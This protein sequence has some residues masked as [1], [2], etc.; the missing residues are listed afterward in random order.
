VKTPREELEHEVKIRARDGKLIDFLGSEVRILGI[1]WDTMELIGDHIVMIFSPIFKLAVSS[2]GVDSDPVG[3][4]SSAN[5][6]LK[7]FDPEIFTKVGG[8]AREAVKTLV[9]YGTDLEWDEVKT[10][11]FAN[12]IELAAEVLKYNI[13]PSLT[14]NLS[15]GVSDVLKAF[16]VNLT[17]VNQGT[18]AKPSSSSGDTV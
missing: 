1:P 18:I 14:K 4:D 5:P 7:M 8:S 17:P 12:V 16:G 9:L 13:G 11:D 3:T 6:Y 2:I 10:T 15:T